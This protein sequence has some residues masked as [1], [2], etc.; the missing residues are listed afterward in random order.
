ML[1]QI[2]PSMSLASPKAH[3]SMNI[4]QKIGAALSGLGLLIIIIGVFNITL[5]NA[6][7]FLTLAL[8][9]VAIGT[10]L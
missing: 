2:D 9:G 8:L 4:Q 5:P 10:F 3:Y 1:N 7:L 6:K